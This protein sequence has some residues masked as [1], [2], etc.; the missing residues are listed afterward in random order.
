MQKPKMRPSAFTVVI[1]LAVLA[2]LIVASRD[3]FLPRVQA[4]SFTVTN[5]NDSGAGSLRQAMLDA[6]ASSGADIISFNISG[7]GIHTISPTSALPTI[8][9]PVV[10]DGTS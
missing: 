5:T 6:N 9:D 2:F 10:I 8:T 3:Q 4:A 1:S 7:A